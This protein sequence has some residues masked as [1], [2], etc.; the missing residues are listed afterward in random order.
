MSTKTIKKM[1]G[2]GA[3]AR[4]ARARAARARE[5][6]AQAQAQEEA[7]EEAQA[8]A[9]AQAQAEP[10][11]T[12]SWFGLF[13]PAK[14][15]ATPAKPAQTS[16]PAAPAAPATVP[17]AALLAASAP[18]NTPA[19]APAP[20]KPPAA[21][22]PE[23]IIAKNKFLQFQKELQEQKDGCIAYY[24]ITDCKGLQYSD[25][26]D[27]QKSVE[28]RFKRINA[29]L[30]KSLSTLVNLDNK[31]KLADNEI[32]D[33]NLEDLFKNLLYSFIEYL[34]KKIY[35]TTD[36]K[37]YVENINKQTTITDQNYDDGVML[38]KKYINSYYSKGIAILTDN[39]DVKYYKYDNDTYTVN[40]TITLDNKDLTN[41]FI[42]RIINKKIMIH[43]IFQQIISG[44]ID[45]ITKDDVIFNKYYSLK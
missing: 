37:P 41:F 5:K 14:P 38:V 45:T 16:A 44:L 15:A 39:D 29:L 21:L 9:Q 17:A 23:A 20:A 22:A 18:A 3:A 31:L 28:K 8:Q 30:K 6:Q 4:A 1:E 27:T 11:K 26:K 19:G 24:K 25:D 36:I 13:G 34:I 10:K 35:D 33:K 2:A 40:T 7:Q 32:K 43:Q 12:G 42:L